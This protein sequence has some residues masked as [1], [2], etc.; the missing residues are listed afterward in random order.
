M[1]PIDV[2]AAEK[3]LRTLFE[4][5]FRECGK[6]GQLIEFRSI[7]G[8]K[9]NVQINTAWSRLEDVAA[10]IE[11]QSLEINKQPDWN[12]YFGAN[13]RPGKKRLKE[14]IC[15]VVSIW[16]DVDGKN[17]KGGKPEALAGLEAFPLTPNII[18][19]S[20]NGFHAY[21]IF[22]EPLLNI[23]PET[24][25]H[26]LQVVSGVGIA[27]RGD[28]A[29]TNMDRVMRIP[30]SWNVKDSL[31]PLPCRIFQYNLDCF[32]SLGDFDDY[33]NMAFK[34]SKEPRAGELNFEG[35]KS[36]VSMDTL[37]AAKRDV[38]K[39]RVSGKIRQHIIT[40]GH[41]EG[42]RRDKTRSG[43]DQAIIT[44][45]LSAGY[46]YETIKSIFFN[47]HLGCSNR[48]RESPEK[49][50][51]DVAQ[52]LRYIE[53]ERKTLTPAR[54]A[55]LDIEA[56]D[57]PGPE[58]IRKIN[59]F[60]IDELFDGESPLGQ[61]FKN[62]ARKAR[63]FFDR[64]DKLLMDIE[65]DDFRCFVSN[66]FG[67]LEKHLKEVSH[68]MNAHIWQNGQEIEPRRFSH[69]DA[70]RN[71]LFVSNHKGGIYVLD[72]ETIKLEDNGH[73][74]V[75]FEFRSDSAGY[76][77]D[78]DPSRFTNYL[79]GG[80]S[81]DRFLD[82]LAYKHLVSLASFELEKDR[83][84]TW[85]DQQYLFSLWYLGLFF[86]SVMQDKPIAC[87]KGVKAS[88]KSTL[89]T[90]AGK[91]LFGSHFQS[92]TMPDDPK[93]FMVALTEN[94]YMVLDN[95]D[96][97]IAGNVLNY[98]CVSATSGEVRRRKLFTNQ[99]EIVTQP[100][101]FLALTT[102]DPKFKRDDVV[103]R[104]LLFNMMKIKSLKG[105]SMLCGALIRNRDAILSETFHNLN[106]ALKLLAARKDWDPC[107]TFRAADW[108][109]FMQ[110]IHDDQGR[111]A[112]TTL[113]N[114]MNR[115]KRAF[116]IEDDD[117]YVL[118]HGRCYTQNRPFMK[119][120][121]SEL[122]T[123]LVAEAEALRMKTF[124]ERYK[125]PASLARRLANIKEELDDEFEI[126]IEDGNNR[127][128]FYTIKEKSPRETTQCMKV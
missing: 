40:G 117:L 41:L 51:W 66:R 54:K 45:L 89:S 24:R 26:V 10:I 28:K 52:G 104:L 27:L 11:K 84:L 63:Y 48:V 1:Q 57:L 42:D 43:R 34:E 19:D 103:D 75:V 12:R 82:S 25:L 20:G 116:S 122:Y 47:L 14:D 3:F 65:G 32:F 29:V 30:G 77:I 85:L 128:R 73:D 22:K 39:L 8:I 68:A 91:I 21:W 38:K 81:W 15:D 36:P 109:I 102:R 9:P 79:E 50:S 119:L 31:F 70:A 61:G 17:F 87:F 13:P 64:A 4:P 69:Y 120:S 83:N 111:P 60:I 56:S 90:A 86:E 53:K 105:R 76:E 80:F 59:A 110:K 78:L 71:T 37:E 115:E 108:D 93:D 49:L 58:K 88:G 94:Y 16:G 100:H 74:G 101:V 126:T 123:E 106:S 95:L 113:M 114:K 107:A 118:L 121:A 23:T 55:I 46:D 5:Y 125:S 44:A 97:R 62:P 72:G 98:I 127:Q 33:R 6:T 112:F 18:V 96:S 7:R 124:R 35:I 2:E 67:L 99:D 92:S